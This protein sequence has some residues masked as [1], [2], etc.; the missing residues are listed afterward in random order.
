[1]WIPA[2]LFSLL[3]FEKFLQISCQNETEISKTF[4]LLDEGRKTI[5]L[6][7]EANVVLFLG[8]S[9]SGK[10]TAVQW[11]AGDNTK[12]ISVETSSGSG[13]YIIEDTKDKIGSSSVS[14]T[15]YPELVIDA[16]TKTSFYDCPGFSDTRSPSYDIASSF[17]MKYVMD[18]VKNV[19]ML[20]LTSYYSM[21][22]GQDRFVFPGLLKNIDDFILDLG[23]YENSIALVVS[24]VEN[25]YIKDKHRK[26]VL[27]PDSAVIEGIAK[28]LLELAE[29]Y[30]SDLQRSDISDKKVRFN[31]NAIKIIEIFLSKENGEYTRIKLFRRPD[32]AGPLSDNEIL[33]KEK[34]VLQKVI[35]DNL[36]FTSTGPNDFGFTISD[37]TKLGIHGQLAV[38]DQ[39]ITAS[40]LEATA[41]IQ[42]CLAYYVEPVRVKIIENN[43]E[44][45]SLSESEAFFNRT[46]SSLLVLSKAVDYF[47]NMKVLTGI[48]G[49]MK[50]YLSDL[51]VEALAS[52][53]EKMEKFS[54]Y[55]EFFQLFYEDPLPISPLT[56]SS[57][58]QYSL[59]YLTKA[60]ILINDKASVLSK[61]INSMITADVEFIAESINADF[62]N[63]V[64]Q[65]IGAINSLTSGSNTAELSRSDAKAFHSKILTGKVSLNQLV[66]KVKVLRDLQIFSTEISETLSSM[67]FKLPDEL[68]PRIVKR[69]TEFQILESVS[70]IK[71][72]FPSVQWANCFKIPLTFI[73]TQNVLQIANQAEEAISTTVDSLLESLTEKARTDVQAT[74]K[75]EFDLVTGE[76]RHWKSFFALILGGFGTRNPL[77]NLIK[78]IAS[79]LVNLNVNEISIRNE[80]KFL[81]KYENCL[82]FLKSL[83][84][85]E[86]EVLSSPS[87]Q[88][89]IYLDIELNFIDFVMELHEI[90]SQFKVQ[91]DVGKYDVQDLVNWGQAGHPRG[92]LVDKRNFKLFME[93][94][95]TFGI[96]AAQKSSTIIPRDSQLFNL[97]NVLTLTL[98]NQAVLKCPNAPG[99]T[100]TLKANFIKFSS[101]LDSNGGLGCGW[102]NVASLEVYA[103]NTL[104]IDQD[105]NTLGAKLALSIVAPKVEIIGTRNINLNGKNGEVLQ[106]A[107]DGSSLGSHG[108]DGISGKVGGSAGSCFIAASS[109][110]RGENLSIK[111]NGGN[112]GNGQQGGNGADGRDGEN[113]PDKQTCNSESYRANGFQVSGIRRSFPMGEE[114]QK[115][116]VYGLNGEVG[117]NGGSCGVGGGVDYRVK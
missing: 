26:L 59:T 89:L 97:N 6:T 36:R 45:L 58:F 80:L 44:T 105:L 37:N 35:S 38:I 112:G 79:R 39:R 100:V 95:T 64:N 117:A 92:I 66:N 110:V 21:R 77:K 11:M 113:P 29:D 23:K 73:E 31:K 82:G 49:M 75:L 87:W 88:Y 96:E 78:D 76:L 74:S 1:M 12:L 4:E 54:K 28:Y 86:S 56:W 15:L 7:N 34:I 53:E 108:Q 9:G 48:G 57:S 107:A 63:D 62:V 101:F 41:S 72:S 67:A 8:A 22:K 55:F 60:K 14:K 98:K 10:S 47:I 85:D 114:Q 30:K 16:V 3:Y 52:M 83:K 71:Y 20:F 70:N 17:F 13:E 99:S 27:K 111:A 65:M 61:E 2:L 19:K 51:N 94:I 106:K 93:K 102:G 115:F 25:I 50:R 24:K 116:L 81:N 104:F 69:C 91:S 18:H 46:E 84:G 109:L 40:I 68:L 5:E 33:T 32:E 42:T 90:L 103:L 43:L